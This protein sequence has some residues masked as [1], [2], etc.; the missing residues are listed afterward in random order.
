MKTPN[1]SPSAFWADALE[2]KENRIFAQQ[3]R[4]ILESFK[5]LEGATDAS[6][7]RIERFVKRYAGRDFAA[8]PASQLDKLISDIQRD[9]LKSGKPI[10]NVYARTGGQALA[11]LN[12]I[13]HTLGLPG[14]S[15][16]STFRSLADYSRR[17]INKLVDVD[18]RVAANAVEFAL[19]GAWETGE[20]GD[21]ETAIRE[22]IGCPADL[23]WQF[24]AAVKEAARRGLKTEARWS[25]VNEEMKR[26]RGLAY[27]AQRIVRSE[28]A[29]A[30]TAVYNDWER[31]LG[32]SVEATEFVPS[33]TACEKCAALEGVYPAGGAPQPVTDTH[34]NCQC[35]TRPVIRGWDDTPDKKEVKANVAKLERRRE[36]IAAKQR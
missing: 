26:N 15:K 32:A 29:I 8:I 19:K 34:P 2:T 6:I 10:A 27:K 35:Q 4:L 24:N 12:E 28:G 16:V 33:P 5:S 20:F 22:A 7:H 21:L 11:D 3:V 18:T 23:R 1:K 14:L 30:D 13:A 17:Y 31:S 25:F 36:S 9:L